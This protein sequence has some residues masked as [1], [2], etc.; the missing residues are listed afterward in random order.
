MQ[1][2]DQF[3][4]RHGHQRG[5]SLLKLGL[6]HVVNVAVFQSG[7]MLPCGLKGLLL[8]CFGAKVGIGLYIRPR[9]NIHFPWKLTLGD[10]VWIG[11]RCEILNFAPV[12]I[13][14]HT[15]LAHDVYLAAG[16]HDL[17]SPTFAYDNAP[18]SIGSGCWLAT[19]AFVGSG[20]TIGDNAVVAA[21]SVVV[22]SVPPGVIAGG[23]PARVIKDRPAMQELPS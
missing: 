3:D 16:S 6:W 10:H 4:P 21:C 20:V 14:S 5:A 9:V 15:A 2:L 1:R 22:R 23:N 8:R 17:S 13:G 18:I 19:R 11:D 12:A 7:L